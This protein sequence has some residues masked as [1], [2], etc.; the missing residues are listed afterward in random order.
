MEVMLSLLC[1]APSHLQR[2]TPKGMRASPAPSLVIVL[3]SD[4]T[5][6]LDNPGELAL[7]TKAR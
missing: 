5:P 1:L 6:H 4:P 3:E 7:I 2:A